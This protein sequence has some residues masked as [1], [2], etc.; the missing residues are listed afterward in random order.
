[1]RKKQKRRETFIAKIANTFF[2]LVLASVM[3]VGLQCYSAVSS[4][5]FA[6]ISDAHFYTG[7]DNTTFK[8]RAESGNLLDDAINQ[9]NETPNIN[10]VMFTGDQIDK[11]FEKELSAFLPH[12]QKLNYPW[13]ITFGNHDTCIGGF[14]TPQVYLDM[15]EK[16]NPQFNFKKPYYSFS[17]QKGYKVIVL[18]TIIRDR[19]TSNGIIGDE[20]LKWLDNELKSANN[21]TVLIFTHVPIVEPFESANHRLL[22]ADKVKQIIE[23]Y[24]NPIG[25]FQGHYHASR[26]KQINN[27]LYVSSPSLVSYPNAFRII[28]VTNHRNKVVFNIETKETNMKNLQKLAKI[29]VFTSSLYSGEEKDQ[30]GTFEIKK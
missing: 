9:I 24:D 3:V 23:K 19:L 22:N 25:V 7:E 12:A 20:Q 18:D 5:K 13:Y 1:M 6:Q 27:V 28:T 17:P 8:L 14:L 2:T 26:I 15:V 16:A 21:D 4:L 11:S 29:M 30:Y 10:F